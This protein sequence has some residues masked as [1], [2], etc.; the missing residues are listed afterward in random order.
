[1][2]VEQARDHAE[3]LPNRVYVIPPNVTL[4]I[5]NCALRVKAPIEPRG[6]RTPIDR[7]F[8]SLAEDRGE[9]AVCI[10]LS[11]TGS[12]EGKAMLKDAGLDWGKD[13]REAAQK[14]VAAI[15]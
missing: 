15:G 10:I 9:N 5:K 3:V 14:I 4:T 7:L 2:A 8:H 13:M 12:D 1:M 11:G 6:H